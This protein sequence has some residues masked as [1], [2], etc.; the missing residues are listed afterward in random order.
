[1]HSTLTPPLAQKYIKTPQLNDPTLVVSKCLPIRKGWGWTA[2]S[3][4]SFSDNP[5][6][7]E[8]ATRKGCARCGSGLTG[9]LQGP[10]RSS[11]PGG[12]I[13]GRRRPRV[14]RAVN[15]RRQEVRAWNRVRRLKR[16]NVHY[17]LEFP[18]RPSE[19]EQGARGVYA[20]QRACFGGRWGG[21]TSWSGRDRS[22]ELRGQKQPPRDPDAPP[23]ALL[24]AGNERRAR[25]RKVVMRKRTNHVL[26]ALPA[27][28]FQ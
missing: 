27:A 20:R 23:P 4:R 3:G 16:E 2:P 14:T 26:R 8:N 5:G 25:A 9:V 11:R 21:L 22:S 17:E 1:M 12:N 13:R 19:D 18:P 24:P 28:R 15:A 10:Q 6:R 7:S